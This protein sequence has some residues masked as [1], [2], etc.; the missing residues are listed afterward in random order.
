VGKIVKQLLIGEEAF[1]LKRH[2]DRLLSRLVDPGL[3]DFNFERVSADSVDAATLKEKLS[4]FPM[5]ADSRT[6]VV[7]DFDAYDKDALEAI[8]S[9]V[10][11]DDLPAHCLFI[12]KK[13]DKRTSF[14]KS[15]AKIGEVVEFKKPYSNQVPALLSKEAETLNL[16][17]EPGAAEL[18]VDTLGPDLMSLVGEI[19]KL[20]L[21]AH[22]ATKITRAHIKDLVAPGLVDNVFLLGNLLGQRQYAQSAQLYRRM[23]EQGEPPIKILSLLI[24]HFRKILLTCEVQNSGRSR[25]PLESLLKVSPFFVK[26]YEA[27]ARKFELNELKTLYKKLMRLS[28]DMRS[29]RVNKDVLFEGF[30]QETCVRAF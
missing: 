13:F 26:D 1:L 23:Q 17:F 30:L 25:V 16:K 2:L 22:P 15:F 24:G 21:Y 29:S 28:E 20:A 27:Q 3:K 12:A 18:L 6:V 10:S 7:E 11:R 9:I 14:Y 19:E 5:M 8:L 4:T